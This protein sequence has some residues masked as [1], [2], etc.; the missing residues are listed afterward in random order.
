MSDL[1]DEELA[2]QV[3]EGAYRR[4]PPPPSGSSAA[5]RPGDLPPPPKV[6]P[7]NWEIVWSVFVALLLFSVLSGLVAGAVLELTLD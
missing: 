6:L 7:I 2:A 3:R 1:S 5:G 4:P